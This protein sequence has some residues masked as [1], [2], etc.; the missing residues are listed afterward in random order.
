M[1]TNVSFPYPISLSFWNRY[2]VIIV[3][4]FWDKHKE[5]LE[6]V[7]WKSFLLFVLHL[8]STYTAQINS[9]QYNSCCLFV[10]FYWEI[11]IGIGIGTPCSA[12]K[13][14]YSRVV[15][16]LKKMG[17][18]YIFLFSIFLLPLFSYNSI[19]VLTHHVLKS[20]II[21]LEKLL[22]SYSKSSYCVVLC[23]RECIRVQFI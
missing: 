9:E 16:E 7:L 5:T 2:R 18:F 13:W 15:S 12:P 20:L 14:E 23:T 11:R 21:N 1:R 19:S 17:F 22:S 8:S 4:I 10:S 6:F 3:I